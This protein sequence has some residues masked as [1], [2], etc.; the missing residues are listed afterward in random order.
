MIIIFVH[1]ALFYVKSIQVKHGGESGRKYRERTRCCELGRE[2]ENRDAD[3]KR[4]GFKRR[5]TLVDFD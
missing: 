2:G 5:S 1:H 4:R 3:R